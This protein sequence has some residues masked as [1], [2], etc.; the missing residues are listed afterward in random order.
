[1]A[2]E[3]LTLD[4]NAIYTEF[5]NGILSPLEPFLRDAR[6]SE[7]MVHSTQG[8]FIEKDGCIEHADHAPFSTRRLNAF[9]RNHAEQLG[10]QVSTTDFSYDG[11][12]PC[13]SRFHAIWP[14][15]ASDGAYHLTIRKH[16]FQNLSLLDLRESMFDSL[17]DFDLLKHHIK[18][19]SNIILSGETG[20]GKT[21]LLNA[22]LDQVHATERVVII[23]EIPEI[24]MRNHCNK[25]LLTTV[26]PNEEGVGGKQISD[27]VR[28]SLIMRPD[29]IILGE[30]RGIEAVDM[31]Q[32]MQTHR[33]CLAT[34]HGR[35]I[36]SAIYRLETLL[37]LGQ[38]NYTPAITQREIATAVD[39]YVQLSRNQAGR[40]FV[41]EI[42]ETL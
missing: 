29:R 30:C 24:D 10:Q 23:E 28:E 35:N 26:P 1:M 31:I 12:L 14:P 16:H 38:S 22:I 15:A 8:I 3:S 18:E 40:R 9:V 20:T 32:A 21:T 19:K 25:A 11:V 5:I 33:G 2:T 13:G 17:E 6:V 36:N 42:R 4:R 34:V 39:L 37:L 7:I 27:L 41:S